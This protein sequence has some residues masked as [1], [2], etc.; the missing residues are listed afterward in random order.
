MTHRSDRRGDEPM[1]TLTSE[2]VNSN[3][4]PRANF[5]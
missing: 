3:G 2:V 1:T 5:P 4:S